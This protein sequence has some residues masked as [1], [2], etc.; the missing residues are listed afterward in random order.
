[1]P[2]FI[3][4]K[5]NDRRILFNSIKENIGDSWEKFYPQLKISRS[6]FF[7][8]LSGRY[9]IPKNIFI[10]FEKVSRVEIKD[11]EEI[12]KDVYLEKKVKISRMNSNLAEIFGIL[13][14]DGHLAPINKEVCVVGNLNEE[15]YLIYLK[16]LFEK[17]FGLKFTL[18]EQPHSLK[19]RVYSKELFKL[20]DEKYNLPKGNKL[21]KLKIPKEVLRSK[22][23]LRCYIK[24]LYDTDGSFY[25]RRKKDP[26]VQITS[27]DPEFLS[28]VRNALISLN[29]DIALGDQR[30]FIYKKDHIDRFFKEIKPA[31]PK[32]LK[33]YQNYLKLTK[34][35]VV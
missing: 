6:S 12:N 8:Y 20:L 23:W 19:L 3:K 28:E 21:G 24:G 27:A 15:N 32:H 33:N 10:Q 25:L 18:Y 26:V 2:I 1:M 16:N 5:P 17:S 7:N 11:Y 9:D 13:N 29:F 30:T 35:L 22:N 31:N 34:A 4:L 14:G